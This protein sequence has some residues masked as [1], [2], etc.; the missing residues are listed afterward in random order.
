MIASPLKIAL[1]AFKRHRSQTMLVILGISMVLVGSFEMPDVNIFSGGL[2]DSHTLK[3]FIGSMIL[4]VF[5]LAGMMLSVHPNGYLAAGIMT[6]GIVAHFMFFVAFM[7]ADTSE[8]DDASYII[9][10]LFYI[11][12]GFCTLFAVKMMIGSTQNTMRVVIVEAAFVGLFILAYL[13]EI[14]HGNK[15]SQALAALSDYHGTVILM[16]VSIICLNMSES[17]YISPMKRLRMNVEALETTTV[18][19]NETY[20]MREQLKDLLDPQRTNWAVPDTP[21][22][23]KQ[24]DITLYNS[25]RRE[26]ITVRKWEGDD[27]LVATVLPRDL[28]V[29]LYKH[30]NFHIRHI[31]MIGDEDTCARIRMYGDNGFFIDV[32]VRD[33]HIKKYKTTMDVAD[34]FSWSSSRIKGRR[35]KEGE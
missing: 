21:G 13:I 33:I 15:P 4:I 6:L 10:L 18:T 14:H 20:M 34:V 25:L 24:L 1:E 3:V 11:L 5:G 27:C 16:L 23:E 2:D 8:D 30:L 12:L 17:K 28:K 26:M 35:A 29:H 7:F 31:A 32:L 19:M 9:R 22:V